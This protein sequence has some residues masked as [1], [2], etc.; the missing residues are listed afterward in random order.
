M[1]PTRDERRTQR[2]KSKIE[3]KMQTKEEKKTFK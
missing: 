3:I 2:E 1:V